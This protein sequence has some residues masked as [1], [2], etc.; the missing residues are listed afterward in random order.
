M[1]HLHD[2][3]IGKSLDMLQSHTYKHTHTHTETNDFTAVAD[4]PMKSL[5]GMSPDTKVTPLVTTVQRAILCIQYY[6]RKRK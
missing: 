5:A 3:Y 2:V 4:G 1:S 6:D